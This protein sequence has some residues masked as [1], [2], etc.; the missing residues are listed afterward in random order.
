FFISPI[1]KYLVEKYD[2]VYTGREI[3]MEYAYVNPF[4]GYVYLK[5]VKINEFKSDSLFITAQG[6]SARL[7][8]FELFSKTYEISHITLDEP[9]F[10]ISQ[11]NK[12]LNFDDLIKR[13]NKKKPGEKKAPV[14]FNML[15]IKINNGTVYYRENIIPINYSVVKVNISSP[16]LK[17]DMDTLNAKVDLLSGIGPGGIKGNI[18]I[19]L[20]NLDYKLDAIIS[21]LQLKFLEQYFKKMSNY[22]S[23]KAILDADIKTNGNFKD[24]QNIN[25]KGIVTITDFHFGENP[26]K[27]FAAFDKFILQVTALN[28]KNKKYLLDSVSLDHPY[29]KY[30]R[31]DYLDNVQMM[32]GKK[33]TVVSKIQQDPHEFNLIL[34]IGN[35]IKALAKNFFKSNYKVNRLAIYKGDFTYND[36][37]LN[38][39][40]SVSASPITITADS[41]NKNNSRVKLDFKSGIKPFGD[42]LVN[43][44]INPKDSSDFD[45]DYRFTKLPVSVFNPYFIRYT[46]FPLDRGSFELKGTW[47]VKNGIIK[48]NNHLL[49]IDPRVSNRMKNKNANWIPLRLIMFFVRERGNVID[50]E[51]PICGNL[52]KP[53]IIF[54]D[55]I[56]DALENIFV[57]PATTPYRT[58]VRNI[59]YEIEESMFLKWNMNKTILSSDQQNFL[60]NLSNTLRE[61]PAIKIHVYPMCYEEKEKEY[62]LFFEAKKNY[63]LRKERRSAHSLSENDTLTIDKMSNKDSL[64]IDYLNSKA[65]NT[66]LFTVQDKCI[67]ILGEKYIADKLKKLNTNREKL[68]NVYFKENGINKQVNIHSTINTT[69]Y[70]GFSY[71]KIDYSGTKPASLVKAYERMHELNNEAPRKKFKKERDKNKQLY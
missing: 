22:G 63:Y 70:N 13:F 6:L 60:E 54:K 7:D 23:F 20:K 14:H 3:R 41:I 31:Y 5:N 2:V 34:E 61:N 45:L 69:P 67:A 36:Y 10:V 47:H 52:K 53:K 56:V 39:K 25:A 18:T 57:K 9:V 44:S 55:A 4:T 68:F 49:V 65:G 12:R 59:E 32:F 42:A 50:Y 33:G 38:E 51:I 1:A 62:I 21:A 24:A 58:E 16:G 15:N 30:E 29:F 71:Y 11:T 43:L 46:S 37:T 64:F 8:L 28:P 66:L 27:D 26:Q 40:F 19:N 35:Y 48:S 17:W